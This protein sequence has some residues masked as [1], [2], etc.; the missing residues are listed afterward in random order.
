MISIK[1]QTLLCTQLCST[2]TD[3]EQ[4]DG[5]ANEVIVSY[6]A[7]ANFVEITDNAPTLE[8]QYL[9][10]PPQP[11]TRPNLQSGMAAY[12]LD[13]IIQN[14]DLMNAR[15]RIR[16]NINERESVS[17]KLKSIKKMT[18][19]RIFLLG[20]MK[21]GEN[22]RDSVQSNYDK[23]VQTAITKAVKATADY[24]VTVA[25]YNSVFPLNFDPRTW[26]ITQLK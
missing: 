17:N 4:R 2:M 25:N 24:R 23:Y 11:S 3:N 7:T 26:N 16:R 10:P 20:K 14:Q 6:H 1:S 9:P 18:A 22:I 15:E 21:L 19:A 5:V 13:A 12:C 8:P